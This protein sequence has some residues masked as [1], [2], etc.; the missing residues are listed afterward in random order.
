MKI[1]EPSTAAAPP[2]AST[3]GLSG[4]GAIGPGEGRGYR[5]HRPSQ[6]ACRRW[7]RCE[8]P[9]PR[10]PTQPR[11]ALQAP[12]CTAAVATGRPRPGGWSGG[13]GRS[14]GTSCLLCKVRCGARGCVWAGQ[15]AVILASTEHLLC[16]KGLAH[17]CSRLPL[18]TVPLRRENR[19]PSHTVVLW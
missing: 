15:E 8:L 9:R 6:P 12:Q 3:N 17:S 16:A 10:P 19:G 14:A 2:S 11:P 18:K 5:L 7:P 13:A 1:T 4:R